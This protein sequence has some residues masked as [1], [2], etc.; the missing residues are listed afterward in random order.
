MLLCDGISTGVMLALAGLSALGHFALWHI[1]ATT[2]AISLLECF[3]SPTFSASIPLIVTKEQLPRSNAMVQSGGA[4]A[5]ILGPLLAGTLV[6]FLS[7]HDI[8]LLDAFTFAIGV[9]TLALVRIPRV[10]AADNENCLSIFEEALVGWRY[11]QQRSGL[12][13]LLAVYSFNHFIFSIATV[14]IMPLLLSFSTP[15]MVGL[16]YSISSCGLLLGGLV[17]TALGGFKKQIDGVLIFSSL[18]GVCLAVHGLWPSFILVASA[19]FVLFLMLPVVEASNASIWQSEV[20]A[21]LQ[22]RCFAV[23]QLLT[24]IGMALGYCL[25]G[26]LSDDV[27]EP[28]LNKRGP[29]SNSVGLLI[30]VGHGRGIALLFIIL[31]T[32]MTL[33]AF[34]AYCVPT[35]RRIGT[36]EDG[37]RQGPGEQTTLCRL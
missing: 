20:P 19:G 21:H 8:L 7:I 26:P 33:T 4:A 11:V 14:L 24:N 23:Q 1:Y 9:V 25:A 2:G 15:A 31:G 18:A 29:L 10:L 28:M 16:Q 37:V 17:M 12:K 34:I 22:G 6:S 3:R 27:F 13:G 5:A 36:L 32:L 30:G 35:I